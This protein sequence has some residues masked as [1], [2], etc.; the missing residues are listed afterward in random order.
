MKTAK[1]FYNGGSQAIRIPKE[2]RFNSNKVIVKQ[3]DDGSLL[4]S[5]AEHLFGK[6]MQKILARFD[7][8]LQIER[9]EQ[10]AQFREELI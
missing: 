7:D 6:A 1:I 8:D 9:A 5:P 2:F 4:L 10:G 3:C